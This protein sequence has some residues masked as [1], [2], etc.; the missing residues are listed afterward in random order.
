MDICFDC[1]SGVSGDMLVG[2]LL[3]LGA[4]ENLLKNSLK[5]LKIG[6]FNVKI[7]KFCYGF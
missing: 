2:A 7:S 4:D 5:S 1:F 3:S 6:D